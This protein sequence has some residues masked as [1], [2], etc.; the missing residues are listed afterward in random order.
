[1]QLLDRTR[2]MAVTVREAQKAA[3]LRSDYSVSYSEDDKEIVVKQNSTGVS[4]VI[5]KTRNVFLNAR[6][7]FQAIAR[8]V[9]GGEIPRTISA[10][11]RE[12]TKVKPQVCE[13]TDKLESPH[14][15]FQYKQ[16]PQK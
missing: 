13:T 8:S 2:E 12:C 9:K 15:Q 10:Y 11:Q 4:L 3:Q 6:N 7:S 14:V 5:Q 16:S 1:M